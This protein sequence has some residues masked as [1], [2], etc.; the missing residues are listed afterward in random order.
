MEHVLRALPPRPRSAV[1]R[2]GIT[3]LLVMLCFLVVVGQYGR[4]GL[5][6]FYLLFPAILLAAVLFDRS[7][8]IYA[9]ALSTLLL[10]LLMKPANRLL[11]PNELILSLVI[12]VLLALGLAVISDG[13]RVAWERAAAAERAKDLLL[14]ELG[15]R[16]RNNLQMAIS[17][18]S[19]QAR[20]KASPEARDALDKAILRLQAIARAHDHFEPFHHNGRIDMR[21]Y[22]ETL[23]NH[24]GDMFREVTPIAVKVDADDVHL[25]TEQAIPLGLIVNEL[26]TNSLKHAFPID[27]AGTVTVALRSG[28]SLTL[29]VEDNGAGCPVDKQERLGSRLTRLLAQQLGAT[30]AWEEAAPGCRVRLV[31]P[32]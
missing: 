9:A 8:G 14:Q 29:T 27:R 24:L 4:A 2:Y 16:T 1:V 5:L 23:C 6:G 18:L 3:T 28:S 25:R 10:Y 20:L 19:L 31:L 30:I 22:L 12:F 26:V 32:D 13:L 7:A 17:V 11:L 15:H 21:H